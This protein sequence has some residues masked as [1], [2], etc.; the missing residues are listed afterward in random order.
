[1][2]HPVASQRYVSPKS[3][4]L[5]NNLDEIA[6][7]DIQTAADV[8]PVAA[9]AAAARPLSIG[10]G[11]IIEL[12]QA[13]RTTNETLA[14]ATAAA[15]SALCTPTN[16]KVNNDDDD[17][18]SEPIVSHRGTKGRTVHVATNYIRLQTNPNKG[19]FEY[20]VTYTPNVHATALRHTL[21]NQHRDTVIGRTKT[22][23]GCVLYL[24]QR[25]PEDS[26]VLQS[27][28]ENDN[29]VVAVRLVYKR[30]KR[31]ADCLHLY[32]VLFDRI[33][34]QMNYVRFGRKR[35]DPTAPSVI[36]Q[37]K[38]E[39]WPGYVTA[40]DEY[41]DGVMLCLDVSH[42]VLCQRT[43]LDLMRE[44]HAAD[45]GGF[46]LAV[47]QA[48]IGAVVLTR[49]NNRTYRIDDINFAA[50]PMDTFEMNGKTI[51]YLEYYKTHYNLTIRDTRQ[52]LLIHTEDRVIVGK[53]DK[54]RV[55]FCLIPEL[56]NLTGLTDQMRNDF[57]LMR[58]IAAI[59]RV[60]PNQ[61]MAS[62]RK[63]C[64]ELNANEKTR[65]LL[66]GWGLRLAAEPLKLQARQLDAE[67]VIFGRSQ[68]HSAGAQA[69][70]SK[71][72]TSR[73]VFKVVELHKWLLVYTR[74]DAKFAERFIECME[75]NS[76]PMG[77]TVKRPQIEVLDADKTD[78]WIRVLRRCIDTQLQIVV[79][80]CPTSRD[81]RYAAIKKVCCAEL[82]IPSQVINAR[83][84]SNETR[85]RAIVQKIALQIN[86]KLG[87][88][89]WSV[90]IPFVNVMICGV[91]TYHD[92]AHKADSVAALVASMNGTYTE[93]F[94]KAILQCRKEELS[95]GLCEALIAALS[96]YQKCNQ[97]LPEKILL[98]RDGV[99]DGQLPLCRDYEVP[100][101]EA[102][103]A[104]L[105]A[106]YKPTL[107]FIVVQKRINTRVF[108]VS[109]R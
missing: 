106:N 18:T 4:I 50:S 12:F 43:V 49:Y 15:T 55:V 42:R 62:L 64:V 11:K 51:S 9:A 37:H 3:A 47:Q 96:A 21:L 7:S 8:S 17:S 83:T 31:I 103:F 92:P 6:H 61:R 100:Q 89:L 93:W 86:C 105:D 85:N 76:R 2:S 20:E 10:R 24:P 5:Q 109:S 98:F 54:E 91:D 22:F 32:N 27:T 84:L 23:D 63:Y 65:E 48:L 28:N 74:N 70:F 40:V 58:D 102:A 19:V 75:K 81:D 14:A 60:T 104:Q 16:P 88:A 79:L 87:G 25:L 78:L 99:G 35:F 68:V 36:P 82:P 72:A 95:N 69:D 34:R 59:T 80:I 77:I 97:R 38:L 45:A 46:Q 29:S 39:V 57:R 67:D 13:L 56:C 41:E 66:D 33:M 44:A 1:M 73:E 90:R 26:I 108:A 101:M 30:C 94:S 107:T 71:Y 53:T 52:P